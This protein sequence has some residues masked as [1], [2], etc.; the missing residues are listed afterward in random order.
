L[1]DESGLCQQIL[2]LKA[3]VDALTEILRRVPAGDGRAILSPE[4]YEEMKESLEN[5]V[6]HLNA[7][8]G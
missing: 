8:A 6:K 3:Q 5:Q 2:L 7:K 4:R 1:A